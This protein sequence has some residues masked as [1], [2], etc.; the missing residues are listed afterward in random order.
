[1]SESKVV[2]IHPK[3]DKAGNKWYVDLVS[4]SPNYPLT[5]NNFDFTTRKLA[6][7]FI[8]Q[9]KKENGLSSQEKNK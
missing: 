6:L 4:K 3:P 1:M 2:Y 5:V 8:S 7:D 9:A